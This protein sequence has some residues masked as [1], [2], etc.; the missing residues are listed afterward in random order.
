MV[1]LFELEV[2]RKS[3]LL[4]YRPYLRGFSLCEMTPAGI[5]R[6]EKASLWTKTYG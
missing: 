2:V 5:S 1:G 6:V 3:Q 4:C